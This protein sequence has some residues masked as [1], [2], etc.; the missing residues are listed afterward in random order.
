MKKRGRKAGEKKD[1]ER[2]RDKRYRHEK[3]N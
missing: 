3:S 1:R 2:I